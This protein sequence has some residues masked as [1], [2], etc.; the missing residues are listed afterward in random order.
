MTAAATAMRP[1]MTAYSRVSIPLSSL[2][3]FLIIFMSFAPWSDGRVLG[4][5]P[6]FR[7]GPGLNEL[8]KKCR[9]H[10]RKPERSRPADH[11]NISSAGG[12]RATV[13]PSTRTHIAQQIRVAHFAVN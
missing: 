8:H 2:R 13:M 4:S 12:I 9:R 7:A 6:D 3:K 5:D 1:A 10:L 11:G